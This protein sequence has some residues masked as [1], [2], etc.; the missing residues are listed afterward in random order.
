MSLE[1][2]LIAFEGTDG[3]GKS[4]QVSLL[5]DRL[6]QAD[7]DVVALPT[8]SDLYRND[9]HVRQYNRTGSGLLRPTSL[10]VMAASDRLRTYDTKIHPHLE[11]GGVV[12][13]DRY[14]YSPEAYFAVRGADIPLLKR[15]HEYLPDPDYAILLTLNAMTRLTRLK[16]RAAPTDWEE[17]DT[18]Y[19]DAIQRKLRAEWREEF[20]IVDAGQSTA[21]VAKDIQLYLGE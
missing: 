14:K 13:C 21:K 1:G 15:I 17:N 4:T 3:V 11:K 12:I 20:A 16:K 8:P 6:K 5:R 2:R 7:Y 19:Q 10:A 9:T 18:S